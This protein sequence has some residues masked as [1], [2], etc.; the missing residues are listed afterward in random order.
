MFEL[1]TETEEDEL[2][3]R[4]SAL[5][6]DAQIHADDHDHLRAIISNLSGNLPEAEYVIAISVLLYVAVE[7][8]YNWKSWTT[9][10][11]IREFLGDDVF[12]LMCC[13]AEKVNSSPRLRGYDFHSN[14]VCFLSEQF[15]CIYE[16]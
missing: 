14:F 9:E 13:L 7:G 10:D 6:K 2:S 15:I 8:G 11:N 4:I 5:L 16:P 12:V 1:D 3:Q